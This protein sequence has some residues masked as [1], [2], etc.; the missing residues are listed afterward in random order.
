LVL[1]LI[2]PE[3]DFAEGAH[4]LLKYFSG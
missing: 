2:V 4:R 3:K 1:S